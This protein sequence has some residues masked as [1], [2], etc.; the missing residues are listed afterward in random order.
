[1]EMEVPPCQS[2]IVRCNQL[3]DLDEAG[4]V[5][6]GSWEVS[7]RSWGRRPLRKEKHPDYPIAQI[8]T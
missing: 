6:W 1:M 4:Q 5:L 8:P 7:F 3:E 2:A